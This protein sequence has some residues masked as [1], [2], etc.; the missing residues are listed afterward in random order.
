VNATVGNGRSGDAGPRWAGIR[1]GGRSCRRRKSFEGQNVHGGEPCFATGGNAVNP[2]I[3]SG[4]QTA[5]GSRRKTVEVVRNHE[6][7]TTDGNRRSHPD[8]GREQ[9]GDAA[10]EP[11][12]VG[13]LGSVRWRGDLW[14]TPREETRLCGRVARTGTRRESR[15]QGQE[16]RARR[17]GS[18]DERPGRRS[19][20]ATVRRRIARPRR[21]AVNGQGA[22]TSTG[23]LPPAG[24]TCRGGSMA[25][26]MRGAKAYPRLWRTLL[27]QQVRES[28]GVRKR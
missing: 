28:R 10:L 18:F 20:G 27:W 1:P 22:A 25:R 9:G 12:G 7:G 15:R 2:T 4:L 14:T 21:A 6:G 5:A 13:F 23:F 3:G 26:T 19:S 24:G 16:G 11:P 17:N 8:G